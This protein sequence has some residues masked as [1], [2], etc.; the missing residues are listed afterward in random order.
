MLMCGP[1]LLGSLTRSQIFIAYST[2][3]VRLIV[4]CARAIFLTGG[5]PPLVVEQVNKSRYRCTK[6]ADQATPGIQRDRGPASPEAPATRMRSQAKEK[7]QRPIGK[8]ISIG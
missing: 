6:S 4:I 3:A 7:T 5:A 8:T 2:T 1:I